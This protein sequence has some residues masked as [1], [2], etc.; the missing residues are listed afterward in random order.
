VKEGVDNSDKRGM[1]RPMD[2]QR[3]GRASSRPS[4]ALSLRDSETWMPATSAGMTKWMD[5]RCV[6]HHR[7]SDLIVKK[8]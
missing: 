3:H 8:P 4:T 1:T 6:D 7:S 2:L 5:R